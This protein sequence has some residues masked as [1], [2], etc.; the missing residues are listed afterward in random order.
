MAATWKLQAWDQNKQIATV[1]NGTLTRQISV[2]IRA[3][4]DRNALLSFLSERTDQIDSPPP[5]DTPPVGKVDPSTLVGQDIPVA[6][7]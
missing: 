7:K 3:L 2:P 5:A 6:A 4:D 1:S